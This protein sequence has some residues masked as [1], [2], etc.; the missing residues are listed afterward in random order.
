M[1]TTISIAVVSEQAKDTL[2]RAKH[3]GWSSV[4]LNIMSVSTSDV[5]IS[6]AGKDSRAEKKGRTSYLHRHTHRPRNQA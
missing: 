2:Y 4:R 1:F 3:R 6:D 5:R